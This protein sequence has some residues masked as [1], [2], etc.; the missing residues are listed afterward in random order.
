MPSEMT[1]KPTRLTPE[2]GTSLVN[3]FWELSVQDLVVEEY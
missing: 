1:I 3:D 2:I